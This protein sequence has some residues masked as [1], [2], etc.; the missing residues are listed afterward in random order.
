[1]ADPRLIL[2]GGV[3]A[4]G[5]PRSWPRDDDPIRLRFGPGG[6]DVHFDVGEVACG[7]SAPLSDETADLVEL[8][9]YVYAADQ[10]VG[11]GGAVEFEYGEKWRRDLRFVVP[12]RRPDLWSDPGVTAAL[13][14]ALGYVTDDRYE[15][16]FVPRRA[17]AHRPSTAIPE[18]IAGDRVEEVMLFSGGLDSLCGAAAEVLDGRRRVALVSHRSCS[19]TFAV[20][21]ELVRELRARSAVPR[22]RPVHVAVTVNKGRALTRDFTQRSRSFLY[23]ALAA[24]VARGN[25]LDRFRVYE[26]GVTSLNLPV[27][28]QVVGARASRTT[29]PQTLRRFGAMIGLV[30]GAAFRIENPFEWRTKPEVIG[31]LIAGGHADLAGL[32]RSCVHTYDLTVEHPH[33]GVCSQCVDRF[34]S[35]RAAGLADANAPAVRY[36][37]HPLTGRRAGAE[38]AFA[39]RYAATAYDVRGLGSPPAFAV[40]FPEVNDAAPYTGLSAGEAVGRAWEM[41]RRHADGV[42]RV[43]TA[44]VAENATRLIDQ[45]IPSDSLLGVSLGRRFGNACKIPD[46]EPQSGETG[47]VIDEGRFEVRWD[48]TPCH[49]GNRRE[50]RFVQRLAHSPG[51]YIPVD[52]LID[53]L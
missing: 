12:V 52:T 41:Y 32:S 26:N 44:A 15:F 13:A 19:Q 51:V 37:R 17:N 36:A 14:D 10:A 8:A 25:G 33:C 21:R 31:R 49:L 48:G 6:R 34:V 4:R 24:A 18:T 11:R 5:L 27:S 1:M 23:A 39:E 20:Q 46:V 38:L 50:F 2:C 30:F 40:R 3:D 35:G 22:L 16:R 45:E 7:V 47:L 53:E 28:P 42:H 9:A 43:L 29:H